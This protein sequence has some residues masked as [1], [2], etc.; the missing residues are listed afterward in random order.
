MELLVHKKPVVIRHWAKILGVSKQTLYRYFERKIKIKQNYP[1]Q[2]PFDYL[3]RISSLK[4]TSLDKKGNTLST[5]DVID[6][7][8]RQGQLPQDFNPSRSTIDRL[9]R[10]YGLDIQSLIQPSPAVHLVTHWPNQVHEIDSTVAPTYY[11]NN[12]GRIA[13]DPFAGARKKPRSKNQHKLILYSAWDHFSGTLYAKYFLAQAENS[14]DLFHF[15]YEFWSRKKDRALPFYGF[16]FQ[17]LYT[18]QGSIWKAKSITSLMNRLSKIVG[19]YHKKHEPGKP[20]ATGGVESSFNTL[21]RFEK[22]LRVRIKMGQHPTLIELNDWLYEFLVDLNNDKKR[23]KNNLPRNELWL[24]NVEASLLKTPPPLIDF[25]KMA[26]TRGETRQLNKFCEISW[27]GKTYHLKNLEDLIGREVLVWHGFKEDAI[28]VEYI[29][30]ILGPFYPGRNEIDFGQ[31]KSFPLTRY[32]KTKRQLKAISEEIIHTKE[33]YGFEDPTYIRQ[34]NVQHPRVS[35][36]QIAPQGGATESQQPL[37]QNFTPD[38]AMLY[39]AMTINFY[40]ENIPPELK[41]FVA[42]HLED[43]FLKNG[44]ITRAQLDDMCHK[45]EPVLQDHGLIDF[46]KEA[47]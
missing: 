23:G 24:Q 46:D 32:E 8:K 3:Q 30:D 44:T 37:Q 14:V 7:L 12:F 19:F 27:H 17:F 25:L 15:L 40:W 18:D 36:H 47:L 45:L 42:N 5:Q 2:I 11:L 39:I 31:Y 43:I 41:D 29:N 6:E 22:K 26:Y 16:P 4:L 1:E 34:D 35:A 38:E 33:D 13:W 28:Y 21:K 9:L 10:K 20:R